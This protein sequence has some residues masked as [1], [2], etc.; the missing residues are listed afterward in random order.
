MQITIKDY[1]IQSYEQFLWAKRQPI[2]RVD[3]NT[4]HI[5]QFDYSDADTDPDLAPHLW[6][7]Q[8][9]IVTLAM[10]RKRFAVFSDVGTGKTGIFLEW[11]RHISKRI[12]PKKTLIISQ[13]HLIQQ[14]MEMQMDFYRWSNILDINAALGG[15]IEKFLS[16]KNGKWAGCPVGI[17]N[18]D[19]FNK[20]FRLQEQIGAIVLDESSCLKSETSIRRSNLISSCRG[21]PYKMCCTATPAPNDRQEYANHALFL[22]YID[23]F[24][25]FFTKY[26]YNTGK[27]NDFLLKPH[28]RRAFYEFLA[29]WSVFLKS[30]ARYGFEDNLHDLKPAEIIWDR[31]GLTEAQKRAAVKYGSSGQM[32]LFGVNVGGITNRAKVS[33]IAKGFVYEQDRSN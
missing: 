8:R 2:H 29:S 6:D 24:K 17:V 13:L 7:Y 14:T 5:E 28:A 32:N 11:V 12:Y 31:I 1:S 19:K 15:D 4:I 25:Q 33:Q 3:G 30:P 22:G 27:G 21:I 18:V 23:N 16:I 9:F 20:P 26:F 10:L